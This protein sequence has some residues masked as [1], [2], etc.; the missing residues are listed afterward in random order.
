MTLVVPTR[1]VQCPTAQPAVWTVAHPNNCFT[2]RTPYAY[3]RACPSS[4]WS[5]SMI[6]RPSPTSY[7]YSPGG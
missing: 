2:P 7:D 3:D 1:A 5:V 4:S 6:L